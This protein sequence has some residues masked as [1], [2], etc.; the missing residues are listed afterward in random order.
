MYTKRLSGHCRI[1]RTVTKIIHNDISQMAY[2]NND[3]IKTLFFKAFNFSF[4]YGTPSIFIIG[5]G[6][7]LATEEMRVHFPPAII[8]T[9]ILLI[10]RCIIF[11]C[12]MDYSRATILKLEWNI[13]Q[14]SHRTAHSILTFRLLHRTRGSHS[15]ACPQ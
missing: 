15:A 1:S 2:C 3:V 13:Q 4:Q 8:N 10:L 14:I 11:G 12:I 6:M 5:F 7:S 9:F